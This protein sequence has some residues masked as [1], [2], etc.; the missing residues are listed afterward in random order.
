MTNSMSSTRTFRSSQTPGPE[1]QAP[2]PKRTRPRFGRKSALFLLAL[3]VVFLSVFAVMQYRHRHSAGATGQQ[4]FSQQ[5]ARLA[6]L[7]LL[8][9]NETPTIA[10]VS[11]STKLR[12]Q[13]F[14][15]NAKNDDVL[16]VYNKAHKAILYRPSTNMII[17][18][19]PVN[20]APTT[21][22]TKNP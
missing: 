6:K 15:D 14:Y 20:V 2:K 21:A 10:T 11:D 22:K 16:F 3:I 12:S 8:P 17:N 18:V 1:I 4:Y 19:A 13:A 9:A 5:N 7:I